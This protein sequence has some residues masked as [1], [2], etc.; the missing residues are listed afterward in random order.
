MAMNLFIPSRVSTTPD[1]GYEAS[2]FKPVAATTVAM[3][4][5]R[6]EVSRKLQVHLDQRRAAPPAWVPA[7]PGLCHLIFLVSVIFVAF[8][9]MRF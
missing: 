3:R 8:R 7:L 5:R 6:H 1:G 2:T 4:A 9:Q